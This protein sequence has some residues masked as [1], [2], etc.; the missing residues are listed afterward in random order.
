M[1]MTMTMAMLIMLIKMMIKMMIHGI[2]VASTPPMRWTARCV[3][4]LYSADSPVALSRSDDEV[5]VT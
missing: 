2:A 3:V 1:T 5:R 4:H